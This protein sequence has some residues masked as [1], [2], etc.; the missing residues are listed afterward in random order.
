MVRV[1]PD[2]VTQ[3]QRPPSSP[4][5]KPAQ[6]Q[7]RNKCQICAHDGHTG[8]DACLGGT[9]RQWCGQT[10]AAPQPRTK[11]WNTHDQGCPHRLGRAFR[12]AREFHARVEKLY[13]GC[14]WAE[15]PA[16]FPARRSSSGATSRTTACCATTRRPARSA[17]SAQP[18]RLFER[19]HAS[20]AQG[21]LVTCEHGNRRV[22]RTEHDGSITVIADRFE[23]KRLNS[24]N[25]VVVEIATA[26]SGSPTRPTAS[27]A[28]TRATRRR[29]R[30]A[31]ATSIASI[32]ATGEVRIVADDFVRPNGLAF[33][34]DERLLYVVDTGAT[35]VKDGPHHIRVF[36]VGDDGTLTGGDLRDLHRRLVRR[37]PL[38]RR[39]AASGRAPATASTATTRTAR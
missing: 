6:D 24:P 12:A 1:L 39:R 32:P 37:L 31:P 3:T 22:T 4:I 20:T 11:G 23:G 34:P 10:Q 9:G 19:Q 29:A 5:S 16:Y 38:R 21:R 15:G 13:E 30:S 14:R 17:C 33:S 18:R 36:G 28:T 8:N 35:H 27:T 7:L 2:F 26:R 25:D